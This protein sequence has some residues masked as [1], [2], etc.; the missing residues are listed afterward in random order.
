VTVGVLHRVEVLADRAER[1]ILKGA[2]PFQSVIPLLD[3]IGGALKVGTGSKRA[4]AM[5]FDLLQ[6]IGNEFHIL[7][8][9]PIDA[10]GEASSR[11]LARGIGDMRAGVVEIDPGYDGRFGKVSV[12]Q[13]GC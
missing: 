11:T 9:A 4:Q 3:L 10:I 7:L 1:A 12:Q 5:Y 2:P 8:D 13:G 6:Q